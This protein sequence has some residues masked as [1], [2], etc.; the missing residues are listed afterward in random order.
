MAT[1]VE[2]PLASKVPPILRQMRRACDVPVP[3]TSPRPI[4]GFITA[5]KLM[6]LVENSFYAS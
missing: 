2:I 5:Y 4:T 1:R 6:P 3:V